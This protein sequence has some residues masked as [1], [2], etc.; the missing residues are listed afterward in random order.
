MAVTPCHLPPAY[1]DFCYRPAILNSQEGNLVENIIKQELQG[2]AINKGNYLLRNTN[3]P[4]Y[5]TLT[6]LNDIVIEDV[7]YQPQ[8][9]NH[10]DSIACFRRVYLMNTAVGH[11]TKFQDIPQ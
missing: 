10:N 9:L 6:S 5:P 8:H 11:S 2:S 3:P 4:R 1:N 7:K